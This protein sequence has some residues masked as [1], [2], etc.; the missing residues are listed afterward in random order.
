MRLP[1]IT[2]NYFKLPE[3]TWDHLKPLENYLNYMKMKDLDNFF[4]NL[5]SEQLRTFFSQYL[6][7]DHFRVYKDRSFEASVV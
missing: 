6:R 2:W 3:F 4:R 7:M 1:E 5:N